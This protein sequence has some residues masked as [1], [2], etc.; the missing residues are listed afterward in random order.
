MMN[1]V[2]KISEWGPII[3]IAVFDGKLSNCPLLNKYVLAA[4]NKKIL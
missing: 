4:S 2:D 3:I 1:G